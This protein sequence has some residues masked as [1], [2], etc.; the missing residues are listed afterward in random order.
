MSKFRWPWFRKDD[1]DHKLTVMRVQHACLPYGLTGEK[2][3]FTIVL[4]S[5]SCGAFDTVTV[6]GKWSL[7]EIR[8]VT[9]AESV[10][11]FI[12]STRTGAK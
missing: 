5:C 6:N 2:S 1:H 3:D 9:P 4:R 11:S 10:Q 8:G 12:E 7:D